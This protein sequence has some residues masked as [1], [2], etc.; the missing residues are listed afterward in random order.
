[1][2]FVPN[3][4][5]VP[6]RLL[7]AHEDGQ[8]VFF[9]GAGVSYPAGLPGFR[10]LVQKLYQELGAE[11]SAVE[12]VALR[13]KLY[14]TAIALL[15]GRI[16]GGRAFVRRAVASIL[17]PQVKSPHATV[18]HEAL[19]TLARGHDGRRRIVTTNFDRLFEA[20]KASQGLSFPSFQ[21]PALPVAKKARWDGL[22]YLHGLLPEQPSE[23][24]LDR[25]VVSSGD[26]GLAYLTERWAARF[27]SEI[28]RTYTI[29]FVG[30]SISDP[31]LR[32]MM[33]ALAA[34]RLLGEPNPEAFAFG[35]YSRGREEDSAAEWAAK[36]VTPIPYRAH[37][38]HV[39]L[40]QTLRVWA[41]T[42]KS[43][44]LGKER[45]VV[46]HAPDVPIGNTREDDIVGRMLWAL[47]DASGL[48]AKRFAEFHPLPPLDWLKE[49]AEKRF[50]NGD[51]S[52]VWH[53]S[54]RRRHE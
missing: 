2:Q 31:V 9:C 40:Q 13:Q 3:G 4:P 35:S 39:Y 36:N 27:V 45:F 49:F 38:R 50:R 8:V 15:E 5:D 44:V 25:I 10:G 51:L 20:S 52:S 23:S 7:E 53:R 12:R 43:G 34:D 29:C 24:E 41:D 30:Y 26:F 37:G 6:E 28:F 33:D 14:D 54:P 18:S 32:Y 1:M 17:S 11:P 46:M 42:Y 48:P 19:L 47:S 22:V 21:A 16:V